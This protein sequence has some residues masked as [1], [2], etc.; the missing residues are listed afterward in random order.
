[1]NTY[2]HLLFDCGKI[3][4]QKT[5]H[6]TQRVITNN[7]KNNILLQCMTKLFIEHFNKKIILKIE[8]YIF[9]KKIHLDLGPKFGAEIML[10]PKRMGPK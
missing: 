1:M 9:G 6:I 7:L 8:F 5:T 3:K 2:Y 10:G 4:T